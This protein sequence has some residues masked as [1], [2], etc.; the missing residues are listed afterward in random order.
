MRPIVEFLARVQWRNLAAMA[1]VLLIVAAIL[2]VTISPEYWTSCLI[3]VGAA[4]PLA[5]MSLGSAR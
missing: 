2:W 1:A 4:Y 3:L 5:I